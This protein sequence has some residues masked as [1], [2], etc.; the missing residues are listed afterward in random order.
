[1]RLLRLLLLAGAG[2]GSARRQRGRLHRGRRR[3]RGRGRWNRN[4]PWGRGRSGRGRCRDRGW[5]GRVGAKGEA[6]GAADE[7]LGEGDLGP[8]LLEGREAARRGAHD[9]GPEDDAEVARGH[10]V[11]RGVAR[12]VVEEAEQ[13]QQHH[14]PVRGQR[15]HQLLAP[16]RAH[17]IVVVIV[18]ATATA[19]A[20]AVARGEVAAVVALRDER[21]GALA[22]VDLEACRDGVRV[23]RGG[24]RGGGRGLAG[25]ERVGERDVR[26]ARRG[27]AEEALRVERVRREPRAR[28]A[29]D[30]GRGRDGRRRGRR[31]EDARAQQRVGGRAPPQKVRDERA[32]PRD[33]RVAVDVVRDIEHRLRRADARRRGRGAART[34]LVLAVVVEVVVVAGAAGAVA[35]RGAKGAGD[36]RGL[37]VVRR[38]ARAAAQVQ[39][40]AAVDAVRRER[41]RL[42]ADTAVRK[43]DAVLRGGGARETD[44]GCG[45]RCGKGTANVLGRVGRGK[46]C[47][48]RG[49]RRRRGALRGVCEGARVWWA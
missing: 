26:A 19:A 7:G 27:H 37:D 31:L 13:A 46:E 36:V 4:R 44:D 24:E 32:Q 9:D 38:G 23:G 48:E 47:L 2:C 39:H 11:V 22:E 33:A 28:R 45:C 3:G 16:R 14:L 5:E 10:L 29:H 6:V 35:G 34:P 17:I 1:M 40:G 25:G 41:H 8:A 21:V 43:A 12:D 49:D 18:I 15:R 20:T 30:R 42:V